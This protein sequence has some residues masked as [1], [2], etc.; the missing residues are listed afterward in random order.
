MNK[1]ETI[2]FI[3]KKFPDIPREDYIF[4]IIRTA[5][6]N[7]VNYE[8]KNRDELLIAISNLKR[9]LKGIRKYNQLLINR[10]SILQETIDYL[11][12]KLNEQSLKGEEKQDE[13]K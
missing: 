3:F 12:N 9:K 7:G 10:M 8:S 1:S 6:N 4:K 13:N 11:D 5:F 2:D